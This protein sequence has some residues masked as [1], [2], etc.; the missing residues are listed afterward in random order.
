MLTIV[1][2][3]DRGKKLLLLLHE[4]RQAEHKRA[5]FRRGEEFPGGVPE[6]S[7]GNVYGPIDIFGTSCLDCRNWSFSP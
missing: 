1:P 6:C 4:I 2:S 3:V 7:M 5:S